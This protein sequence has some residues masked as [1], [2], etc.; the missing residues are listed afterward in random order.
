M[1]CNRTAAHVVLHQFTTLSHRLEVVQ[2]LAVVVSIEN[3]VRVPIQSI[4]SR[5]IGA[6]RFRNRVAH[7]QYATKKE[8]DDL[9]FVTRT[10]QKAKPKMYDVRKKE[11]Q[12]G[13]STDPRIVADWDETSGSRTA[14]GNSPPHEDRPGR[15]RAFSK[16]R[17]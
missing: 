16:C 10:T 14:L 6:N 1:N 17:A 13:A 11:L 2:D 12:G 8:S 4:I 15:T 7:S 9:V 3:D 5:F